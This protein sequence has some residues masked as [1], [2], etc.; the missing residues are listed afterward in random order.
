MLKSLKIGS[1][2]FLAIIAVNC[3]VAFAAQSYS[4]AGGAS[5]MIHEWRVCQRVTNASGWPAVFVPTKTSGEWANFRANRPSHVSLG[6][7]IPGN[8]TVTIYEQS[9]GAAGHSYTVSTLPQ[10]FTTTTGKQYTISLQD[11]YI[12]INS[13]RASGPTPGMNVIA[14]RLSIPGYTAMWANQVISY[15]LGYDGIAASVPN[16]L[17][18]DTQAGPYTY[19]YWYRGRWYYYDKPA[20]LG[21]GHTEAILGFPLY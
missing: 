16:L 20:F 1:L 12:K 11:P 17:G 13:Y 18:P 5:A 4:V 7:C 3:E 8:A 9:C 19:P 21:N 2:L 10:S 15:T 14:V 6:P